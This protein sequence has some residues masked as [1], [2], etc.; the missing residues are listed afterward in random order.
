MCAAVLAMLLAAC[1]KKEGTAG[2]NPTDEVGV[3][4]NAADGDRLTLVGQVGKVYNSRAF[5]LEGDGNDAG[6]DELLVLSESPIQLPGKP[7]SEDDRVTVTGSV[8]PFTVAELERDLGW[9]FSPDFAAA[10]RDRKALI[11]DSVRR[12]ESPHAD[13]GYPMPAA[14]RVAAAWHALATK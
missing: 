9:S 11:V 12:L 13:F 14:D 10:W 5:A 7:L 2:Q 4:A 3:S 6:A 8:R 1:Q